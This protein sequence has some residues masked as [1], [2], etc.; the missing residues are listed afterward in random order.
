MHGQI[1]HEYIAVLHLF[2]D[3]GHVQPVGDVPSAEGERHI[4]R[5]VQLL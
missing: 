5:S 3:V 2:L 1:A 4:E